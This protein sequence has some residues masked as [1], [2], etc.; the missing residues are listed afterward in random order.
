MGNLLVLWGR[1]EAAGG[2]L[3]ATFVGGVLQR[4]AQPDPKSGPSRLDDIPIHR[5]LLILL[6]IVLPLAACGRGST[7]R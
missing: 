6:G 2:A 1:I 3:A 5:G 4:Q 7:S